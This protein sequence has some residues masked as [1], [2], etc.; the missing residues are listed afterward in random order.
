MGEQ[1]HESE[2]EMR[3]KAIG[4]AHTPYSDA[5]KAPFQGRFSKALAV[6]E[7]DDDYAAGLKDVETA[8]ALYV[9]Y[10]A[11]LADRGTLQTATPWGPE[12]R[13]VFACRSPSRPNPVNLCVVELIEREGNR[14]TVRGLDALDGSRILDIKP[15]SADL[16]SLPDARIGWYEERR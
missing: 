10:W 16:D 11:H 8:A 6:L 3:L 9:L 14:L 7:I 2:F 4:T 13:G 12:A 15:Y 5:E 1:S